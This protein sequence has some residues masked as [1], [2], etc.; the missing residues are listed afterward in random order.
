M[1]QVTTGLLT[2]LMVFILV[3]TNLFLF[4]TLGMNLYLLRLLFYPQFINKYSVQ[5]FMWLLSFQNEIN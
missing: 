1:T 5:I 3:S 4:S 2:L